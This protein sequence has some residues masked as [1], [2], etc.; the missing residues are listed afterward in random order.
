MIHVNPL[1]QTIVA[2]LASSQAGHWRIQERV[3]TPILIYLLTETTA[4]R[5][6]P[7]L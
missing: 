1:Q 7:Q 6:E 3:R 5:F 4:F 2:P